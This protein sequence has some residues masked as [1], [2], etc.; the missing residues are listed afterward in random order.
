MRTFPRTMHFCAY[1]DLMG[2]ARSLQVLL[3]ELNR[4]QPTPVFVYEP[5]EVSRALEAEGVPVIIAVPQG[6]KRLS[7]WRRGVIAI[8]TLRK[9][10]KQYDC[11]VLHTLNTK[12]LP[13][14]AI[15]ARLS[16]AKLVSH[17][18]EIYGGRDHN[19][20]LSLSHRIITVSD[21]V[22]RSLPERLRE[23]AVAV[24]NA[25]PLPDDVPDRDS[26]S[27][28]KVGA[29]GRLTAE[30]GVDLLLDAVIHLLPKHDFEVF[31]VGLN[32]PT[33]QTEFVANME[34]KI[35]GLPVDRTNRIN[36][37]PFRED[38]AG[39][40]REMD[41]VVQPSRCREGFGRVAIEAMAHR[42]A[43]IVAGHGGLA[44]IVDHDVNGLH[45]EPDNADDLMTQLDR[46]LGDTELR[47]RLGDA[48]RKK[49]ERQ[50]QPD[51]HADAIIEVY[52]DAIGG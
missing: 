24:Y 7:R 1:R 10:I 25:Y 28:L 36:L 46:L 15:A 20:H 30:K 44:E 37:L 33:R 22:R 41:I 12:H 2:A 23:R 39:F 48:G 11:R 31:M 42:C 26:R 52:R 18:R 49:V 16:G 21:E 35:T 13:L 29:A 27:I 17:Q 8:N 43:V 40:Y 45:H 5:S 38:I 19:K 50:F 4:R 32:E 3:R 14:A 9:A 47:R 34:A 6:A 51:V